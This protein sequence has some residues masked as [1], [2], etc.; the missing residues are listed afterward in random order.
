MD[1]GGRL[2]CLPRFLLSQLLR[3]KPP[4]FVI[5]QGQKL[6][7]GLP[8]A[9]LDLLQDSR[10]IIHGR[11]DTPGPRDSGNFAPLVGAPYGLPLVFR[12]AAYPDPPPPSSSAP[13]GSTLPGF[14]SGV[15]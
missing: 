15:P 4:E 1:Q 13:P 14:P 3:G 5:H 9:L 2:K 10:H 11:N 12:V 7:R 6:L 8:I